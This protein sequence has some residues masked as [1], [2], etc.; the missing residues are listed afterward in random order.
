MIF[1]KINVCGVWDSGYLKTCLYF[2]ILNFWDVVNMGKKTVNNNEMDVTAVPPNPDSPC[3]IM[4][5]SG[6]TGAPKGVV[7]THKNI[8]GC[9]TSFLTHLNTIKF[10]DADC[11]IGY[12]PLGITSIEKKC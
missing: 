9:V 4:Y 7:V 6:S 8:V 2:R 10:S 5:T 1:I 3:I 12:L 11:Y